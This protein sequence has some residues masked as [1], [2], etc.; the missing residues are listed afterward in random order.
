MIWDSFCFLK[1]TIPGISTR[2]Y[3]HLTKHAIV[4][5]SDLQWRK[6]E[7]P[8]LVLQGNNLVLTEGQQIIVHPTSLSILP[9]E[10]APKAILGP[11][12]IISS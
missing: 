2:P 9:L 4:Q 6:L 5:G 11:D 7:Q 3:I 10:E 1:W 8:R 12:M